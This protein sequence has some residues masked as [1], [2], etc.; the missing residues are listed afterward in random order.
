[1]LRKRQWTR[2]KMEADKN[3]IVCKA[4]LQRGRTLCLGI[5]AGS[6]KI[7]GSTQFFTWFGRLYLVPEFILFIEAESFEVQPAFAGKSL[8]MAS[9]RFLNRLAAKSTAD[10][11]FTPMRRPSSTRVK[12][13]SPSSCSLAASL[14]EALASRSSS[15]SAST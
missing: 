3:F 6:G 15:H 10:P 14:P 1:M 13:M 7:Y 4:P 9:K 2:E 12:I 8:P 5:F 11:A